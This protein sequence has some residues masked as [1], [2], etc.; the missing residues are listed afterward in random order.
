MV[1]ISEALIV[2]ICLITHIFC[3]DILGD[4]KS[5]VNHSNLTIFELPCAV[6]ASLI[7]IISGKQ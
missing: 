2:I 6:T 7:R 5:I 3:L 4:G 1:S